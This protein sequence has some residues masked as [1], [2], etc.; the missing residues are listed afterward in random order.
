MINVDKHF[1]KLSNHIHSD[2][3][4][5]H[6]MVMFN[7]SLKKNMHYMN[8]IYITSYDS[9]YPAEILIY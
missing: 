2:V 1:W 6:K 3:C 9:N 7:S 8:S 5:I 4:H